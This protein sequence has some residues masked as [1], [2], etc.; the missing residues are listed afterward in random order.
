MKKLHKL[1]LP[2][3]LL[4]FMVATFFMLKPTSTIFGASDVNC[5]NVY[6][7][8]SSTD[9]TPITELTITQTSKTFAIG[10]EGDA[11]NIYDV[12]FETYD[13]TLIASAGDYTKINGS[14]SISL[15]N[16]S[17]A[18]SQNIYLTVDSKVFDL[19]TAGIDNYFYV[20]VTTVNGYTQDNVVLK[21]NVANDYKYE[22]QKSSTTSLGEEFKIYS[23]GIA[24]NDLIT[25]QVRVQN[26]K[27]T[28]ERTI[29]LNNTYTLSEKNLINAGIANYFV[30]IDGYISW[31]SKYSDCTLS[32]YNLYDSNG[33]I[34]RKTAYATNSSYSYE[35]VT[36]GERDAQNDKWNSTDSFNKNYTEWSDR[37][38]IGKTRDNQEYYFESGKGNICFYKITN[39]TNSEVDPYISLVNYCKAQKYTL[40]GGSVDSDTL[41]TMGLD[42]KD[43]KSYSFV[44]DTTTPIVEDIYVLDNMS[45][46]SSTDTIKVGVRFSEPVQV[47]SDDLSI[48]L[49]T[50]TTNKTD[51]IPSLAYS[52]GAGTNT[53]VFSLDASVMSDSDVMQGITTFNCSKITSVQINGANQIRDYSSNLYTASNTVQ[54]FFSSDSY[55]IIKLS[56]S[57]SQTSLKVIDFIVD[58][59][60]PATTV[61]TN[62]GYKTSK[63]KDFNVNISKVSSDYTFA[64]KIISLKELEE[65]GVD[66]YD[67]DSDLIETKD[68]QTI[69]FSDEDKSGYYYIY[70]KT[71]SYY[72]KSVSNIDELKEEANGLIN[73][74][75]KESAQNYLLK[76]DNTIPE[77]YTYDDS[78]NK[79]ND[80]FKTEH[81]IKN[82]GV[83]D[84]EEY[85]FTFY[86]NDLPYN[87]EDPLDYIEAVSLLYSQ[88]DLNLLGVIDTLT[89][90]SN[91]EN[92]KKYSF[93][94]DSNDKNKFTFTISKQDLIDNSDTIQDSDYIVVDCGISILDSAGNVYDISSASRVVNKEVDVE[95]SNGNTI[96][97]TIQEVEGEFAHKTLIFDSRTQLIGNEHYDGELVNSSLDAYTIGSKL[98]YQV[99]NTELS[100]TSTFSVTIKKLSYDRENKKSYEE[101]MVKYSS[102]SDTYD[103]NLYDISFDTDTYTILFKSAGYYEVV[104]DVD[105]AK[106]SETYSIYI[107][108]EGND[109]TY[110]TLNNQM[111]INDVYALEDVKYYYYNGVSISTDNYNYSTKAQMFSSKTL[112][113]SYIKYYEYQDLTAV[114][115]T[116]AI[117]SQLNGGSSSTYKKASGETTTAK[118]GQIWIK[119][120][121]S[122]WNFTTNQDDWVYYYYSEA[123]SAVVVNTQSLSPNLRA[124]INS[125]VT[126]IEGKSKEVNLVTD[127]YLVNGV[128]T[129]SSEQ[130]HPDAEYS[131]QSFSGTSLRNV[132]FEGDT[133]IH[134]SSTTY[135]DKTFYFYSNYE[136]NYSSYT[137]V[138][139]K[140]YNTTSEYK[141]LKAT[142]AGIPLNQLLLTGY[143][144]LVEIDEFGMST[145][146]IYIVS[147]SD[148]PEIKV[149]YTNS[150]TGTLSEEVWNYEIDGS[151]FNVRSFSINS[152]LNTYDEY[153]YVLIYKSN[154][155][156]S[157]ST[158]YKNDFIDTDSSEKALDFE[159]GN[160]TVVVSDR[161]G[162]SYSFTVSLNSTA[163]SCSVTNSDNEYI[164]FKCNLLTSNVFKFSVTLNGEV[165]ETKYSDNIVYRKTGLYEFYVEDVYGN[166]DTVS[167]ELNRKLPEVSWYYND[168]SKYVLYDSTVQDVKFNKISSNTYEIITKSQ[169]QFRFQSDLG[170]EFEGDI[171]YDSTTFNGIT[172]VTIESNKSFRLKVYYN[173]YTEAYVDYVVTFDDIVP[174]IIA[175]T[176]SSEYTYEDVTKIKDKDY[177]ITGIG[178][179]TDRTIDYI[180]VDGKEIYTGLINLNVIDQSAVKYLRILLNDQEI[181]LSEEVNKEYSLDLTALAK[182][183]NLDIYGIY[184][185]IA[186]DVLGNE[187]SLEFTNKKPNYYEIMVDDNIKT[188]ELDPSVGMAEEIY[189]YDSIV[190]K[191]KDISDLT[192]FIDNIY[193][194]YSLTNGELKST[195]VSN[196]ELI[197]NTLNATSDW[198]ED[199]II[200]SGLKITYKTD[201]TYYYISI[202]ANDNV[203]HSILSRVISEYSIFPLYSYV[204][205]YQQKSEIAFKDSDGVIDIDDYI[206]YTNKE[207]SVDLDNLDS[208]I[209]KILYAYNDTNENFVFSELTTNTNSFGSL[210][211]YYKFK[212][213]NKYGNTTIYTI[214]VSRTFLVESIVIH[215]DAKEFSYTNVDD[216]IYYSNASVLIKIYN[217]E[218]TID[219]YKD[220]KSYF[221][222]EIDKSNSLFDLITFTEFGEYDIKIVDKSGNEKNIKISLKDEEWK[223]SDAILTGFNE[224]ALKKSELYTNQCIT[225]DS[226]YFVTQNVF[227]ITITYDDI[228]KVVYDNLSQ[229]K[230]TNVDLNGIIGYNGDGIYTI[231]FRNEYGEIV[232][233]N[234]NYRGTD[235]L[236]ILRMTRSDTEYKEV[237]IK[238][239]LNGVYSNNKVKFET[240]A[241]EYIFTI[242][243]KNVDCPKELAFA[244]A[245]S[246]G[247]YTYV[248]SYV[249]EYGFKYS[250]EV[251]LIRQQISYTLSDETEEVDGTLFVG[252]NFSID[253]NPDYIAYYEL[254][255]NTYSYTRNDLLTND[256]KYKITIYDKAG[257][258]TRL[259]I[260]KDTIVSYE[261]VEN[262]SSRILV[263]GDV[264]NTGEVFVRALDD[265]KVSVSKAYLNG[266]EQTSIPS[267][268]THNGK[269]EL[270][271]E[272]QYGNETYFS[273][274]IYTQAISSFEYTT[275]YNYKITKIIYRDKLDNELS[276]I[277]SVVQNANNSYVKFSDDGNYY[278]EMLSS[279]TNETIAFEININNVAPKVTLIGVEN[280]GKTNKNVKLSGY[281]EGDIIK[282]YKDG[283]LSKTINV[284]SDNMTSPVIS[285]MGDYKIEI[286]NT[287]GNTTTLEFRRTYTANTA[288]SIFVCVV[289]VVVASGLFIGLYSRKREKID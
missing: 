260:K 80:S 22:T 253:F 184:K 192:L 55:E 151:K 254:N 217:K 58:L 49:G 98:K 286:I 162:N 224:N 179:A 202:K 242:D 20:K 101:D 152:I 9:N 46:V 67:Y 28:L 213:I 240:E 266:A 267:R 283:S 259:I 132:N 107:S 250:F 60:T 85:T 150:T 16:S 256:G 173:D 229:A 279:A 143:Y 81:P 145:T 91:S 170:F 74:T 212:V 93:T 209:T 271:L 42:L 24:S 59:R 239:I 278:I 11:G 274:Y 198:Q 193:L 83:L 103:E 87:S 12:N 70:W 86:M 168:N 144:E 111:I 176:N 196:N 119:Y 124:A 123:S 96:K 203:E 54:G 244:S 189:G 37:T 195:Y 265:D 221:I 182:E 30:G 180:I 135:D 127:E 160:Y 64:Y 62:K 92:I 181:Y 51:A 175:K 172:R 63:S 68:K 137:K 66:N 169:L 61:D 50:N 4:T 223:L 125:I 72:G 257:N 69:I 117:A 211:G 268:Y 206:A 140:S 236:N 25:S 113:Q 241:S 7:T 188:L 243:N 249:D 19:V 114:V 247:T 157:Y 104:F 258:S 45:N 178:Y 273:F 158:Y 77:I 280:G 15:Q 131:K 201:G 79:V 94:Q 129:L 245:T 39:G 8:Q 225:I 261:V 146:L 6:F 159:D 133:N 270:L 289:L 288:S 164:R 116:S 88:D 207:F 120:K 284:T 246:T 205:L 237:D 27:G 222:S 29:P 97:Q 174:T 227:Y 220:E 275:P 13:G 134:Q 136:M 269:W 153:A 228:E 41:V 186:I 115:L 165:I 190:Y 90:Y 177:N 100:D 139:Y 57:E 99:S 48:N 1:L 187:S 56:S 3:V 109:A 263:N 147:E 44:A 163:I 112:L 110:N 161:F 215:K 31:E 52:Y 10:V 138:Y 36:P 262:Y 17:E 155:S 32:E 26:H 199:S 141:E 118:S 166:T 95:D 78:S 149:T 5:K 35:W 264:S 251:Y 248:L 191:F 233:K 14:R 238:D 219:I 142:T 82:E 121:R 235:T 75:I 226:S 18:I 154:N 34:I 214:V 33:E 73:G 43:W 218:Y 23:N 232:E 126:T 76:Y 277:D 47:L 194:S 84:Y 281:K 71:T 230:I 231:K 108:N 208:N 40:D 216:A 171:S 285:E 53:L 128:P 255:D 272:D 287:V 200:I 183:K 38:L 122:D 105:G 167:I 89:I 204:L 130:I 2:L 210:D 282:I 156:S 276:Y 252:K 234:V 197:T 106:Y 148:A 65:A 102:A 185:I 21:V